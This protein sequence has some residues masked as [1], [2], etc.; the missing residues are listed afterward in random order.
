VEATRKRSLEALNDLHTA[1]AAR[2]Q[3]A[4]VTNRLWFIVIVRTPIRWRRWHLE[5][6]AA[7]RELFGAMAV[8]EQP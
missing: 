6:L 3:E 2:T 8:G 7:Q 5:Q 1:A 4:L